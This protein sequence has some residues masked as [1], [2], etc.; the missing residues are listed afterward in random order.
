MM[1][2]PRKSLAP[3]LRFVIHLISP[4]LLSQDMGKVGP[5]KGQPL[6]IFAKFVNT[7]SKGD[8]FVV[9]FSL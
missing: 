4:A 6:L 8:G 5:A 1:E 3:I 7:D 9:H 2:N